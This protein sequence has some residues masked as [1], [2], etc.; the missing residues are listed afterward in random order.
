[1]TICCIWFVVS[2]HNSASNLIQKLPSSTTAEVP[3]ADFCVYSTG[4][5]KT[6]SANIRTILVLSTEC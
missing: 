1:M 3:V 2:I 5:Y 4:T 6:M